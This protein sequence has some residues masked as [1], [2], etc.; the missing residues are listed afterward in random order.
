MSEPDPFGDDPS[1]FEKN[2]LKSKM[3]S[4]EGTK[5][6]INSQLWNATSDYYIS[7]GEVGVTQLNQLKDEQITNDFNLRKTQYENL[8]NYLYEQ[9]YNKLAL[10]YTQKNMTNKQIE[11][12]NNTQYKILEQRDVDNNLTNELTTKN[13]EREYSNVIYRKQLAEIKI[14]SYVL[15]CFFFLIII[16]L[17]LNLNVFTQ[18]GFAQRFYGI[19]NTSNKKFSL[20]YLIIVL[21]LIIVFRQF[22]LAILFLVV[23]AIITLLTDFPSEMSFF[24]ETLKYT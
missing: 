11:I 2:K 3:E 21:L 17:L 22:S 1:D 20:V 9:Y 16:I 19:L 5:N 24:N 14:Y 4:L 13:R 15:G 7:Q 10:L 18:Q 12:I 23:Y 8:M 6:N